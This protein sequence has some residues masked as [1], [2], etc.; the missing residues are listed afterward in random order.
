MENRNN[1]LFELKNRVKNVIIKLKDL[2]EEEE[3]EF[4]KKAGEILN[5]TSKA[6]NKLGKEYGTEVV[7]AQIVRKSDGDFAY[8]VCNK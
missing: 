2:T 6:M 5:K 8:V 1:D 7:L 3:K 4:D